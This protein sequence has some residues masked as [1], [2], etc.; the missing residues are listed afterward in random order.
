MSKIIPLS[1]GAFTVD[2][3]KK[4]I[5]FDKQTDN[6]QD[7]KKGSLLVEIQPF[8]VITSNDIILLDSGLG[9][10]G[11]DGQLQIHKNLAANGINSDDVTKVLMSHLHKDHTGG[12]ARPN[13]KI[14]SFENAT[15]YINKNEWE[16]AFEKGLPSYHVNNF[17]LLSKK[18]NL[19]LTEGDGM[20]DDYISYKV[21]GAHTPYHQ[22]FKISDEGSII[23]Y[24]GD[25]APQLQQMKNRF[26][27]KYDF[28]GNASMELRQKWWQQGQEEKWT[29]LFYHDIKQPTFSFE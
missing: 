21:T 10:A 13:K 9:F 16:Y 27:A 20:I 5:P 17:A 2:Q 14:I 7:R 4:F 24:G 1:E 26:K 8:V 11:P 25:V 22:V 29:F 23:F 6:L 18:E 15:Y 19:I 28:D 12:I 3:T